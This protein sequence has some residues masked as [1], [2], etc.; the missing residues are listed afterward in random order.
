MKKILVV[1]D[2]KF[3]GSAYKVSLLK[4]GF[5]VKLAINGVDALKILNS[6][7]PDLIIL[8]IV[9][10]IMDGFTT[11]KEIKSNDTF[12]SIPVI[13]ASNLGQK[14]DI[15]KGKELGAV[16]YIIKSDIRLETIVQKINEILLI[17]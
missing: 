3:L 1:E 9:M 15:D 2:D 5:E 17:G 8:D 7:M 16:G 12:K 4:A 13:I 11:L 10:P 6:F 14:E